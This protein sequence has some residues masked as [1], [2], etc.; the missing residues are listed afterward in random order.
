MKDKLLKRFIGAIDDRDEYQLQEIH[1]ELA[2]SGIFLWCM[3]MLVMFA[4]L[5]V[6]TVQNT[7][8]FITV[9]LFIVNMIYAIR[10]VAKLRKKHLDGTDCATIE[11]YREKKK[12]LRKQSTIAGV[13]WAVTMLILMQYVFPYLSTGEIDASWQKILIWVIAGIFFGATLYWFAKS[14]LQKHF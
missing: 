8:T 7:L 4:S 9:A 1:K 13:A 5:V 2:F 11:E 10:I 14:K 12:Q 3:T 6:D